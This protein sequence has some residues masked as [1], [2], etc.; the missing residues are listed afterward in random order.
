MIV[1]SSKRKHKQHKFY[2][3]DNILEVVEDYK[4][5]GID[6]NKSL[7]WEG[8]RRKKR[9]M[10]DWKAFYAFQNRCRE[11]KLWDWKTMQTLFGILVIP[12][13]LYGCEVWAN[14]TS[15]LQWKQIEKIQKHMITSKFKIKSSVPYEI[16]LSEMG[17]ASIEAIAM[18]RL[19]RYLKR[20]EQMEEGRWPKVV[21][22][23]ILCKRKK[24][25]MQQNI[26]WLSNWHICL[27][28]CPTNSKE[29]ETFVIDK[30][31]KQTSDKELGRKKKVLY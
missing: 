16:M 15:D 11:A 6:F 13:V 24:S 20:V 9:T 29:I 27:N 10:G 28:M 1:F 21:F 12:V 19:I 7:G 14:S 25:W 17:V 31:H 8:Y 18:V 2:F 23:D 5:L 22:N 30:F 26:N 4:Y 3:E